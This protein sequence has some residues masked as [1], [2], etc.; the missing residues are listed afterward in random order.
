MQCIQ[1]FETTNVALAT[2]VIGGLPLALRYKI[3]QRR[4]Y[5]GPTEFIYTMAEGSYSR[6]IGENR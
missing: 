4:V 1:L 3:R 5:I 6:L 2:D